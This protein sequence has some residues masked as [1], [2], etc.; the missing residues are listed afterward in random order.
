MILEQYYKSGKTSMLDIRTKRNRIIFINIV[1][2]MFPRVKG[3]SG[4]L[5]L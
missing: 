5:D 1:S 3:K 4:N 2:K